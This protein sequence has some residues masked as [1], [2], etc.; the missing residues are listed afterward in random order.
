VFARKADDDLASFAGKIEQLVAKN[1]DKKA[2]G[3]VICLGDK[4]DFEGQLAKMAEKEKLQHV[5]LTVAKDGAE[6]PKKYHLNKDVTFT[7][8]VY[9]D[10]KKVTATFAVQS[11]DA[12]TQQEALVA[13]AK[14]LGVDPPKAEEGKK[15]EKKPE[16]AEK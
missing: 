2:C 7:I 10:D 6:G 12:K 9:G 8:V 13:F 4:K 3:T 11:L 1:K 5:P 15:D 16:K 14:V